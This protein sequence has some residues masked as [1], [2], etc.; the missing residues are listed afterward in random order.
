[1]FQHGFD[2]DNLVVAFTDSYQSK[3]GV[4]ANGWRVEL[5]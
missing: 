1:M 3:V 4:S 5:K 2:A